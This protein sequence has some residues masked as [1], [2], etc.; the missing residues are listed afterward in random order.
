M[1]RAAGETVQPGGE[2]QPSSST[3]TITVAGIERPSPELIA[4]LI[5][6]DRIFAATW[7]FDRPD[8]RDDSCSAYDMAVANIGVTA[9]LTDK[10]IAGLIDLNRERYPHP[11]RERKGS[12]YMKYI[13]RTIARARAV[14]AATEPESPDLDE[15]PAKPNEQPEDEGAEPQALPIQGQSTPPQP[16]MATP[17]PAENP[18]VA[19]PPAPQAPPAEPESGS[20]SDFSRMAPYPAPMDDAA[21]HGVVGDFVRAVAPHTEADPNVLVVLFLAYTGS[22]LGRDPFMWIGGQKH[23]T[24]IFVDIVGTSSTGR[25]GSANGPLDLFFGQVDSKWAANMQSGLSSGE[26]LI[27]CVRDPISKREKNKK[28]GQYDDV[29]VDEGVSDK[30]ALV[31]QPEF[32]G[33]LQAMRRSGNN[34]SPTI[35]DA[36]DSGNLKTMTKNSPAAAT[37][38]HI[39]IIGNITKE[40]LLRGMLGGEMDNGFA[41][42]F[43]WACS[44]RSKALP[45][46]GRLHELMATELWADLLQRVQR[47]KAFAFQAGAISRDAAASD[48]WGRDNRPGEGAYFDLTQERHGLF[49]AATSRAAPQVLRLSLIYALLDGVRQIRLEH[50]LAAL[51]VWRYCEDSARYIFGDSMGDPTAD[52]ILNGLRQN[53]AGLT[54][55]EI[56]DLFGGNVKAAEIQRALMVLHKAAL[57][58]FEV[59]KKEGKGRKPERWLAVGNVGGRA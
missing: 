19:S 52:S 31:K 56:S 55:K 12:E 51:E 42:R 29:L 45:E 36:W 18:K 33:A 23:H 37:N 2:G 41:N 35:R 53:P 54:R 5:A 43:L 28:T 17:A 39:T 46:G 16:A 25:K 6:N 27:W 10:A 34:L 15:G 22:L 40:E 38:A 57:A 50:L 26:G 3:P 8:F 48:A 11:K 4:A 1:P 14:Q 24:N 32:F 9:G 59:E 49:G 58:R 44:K 47:A 30:R 20:A 7:G 21:Y 13:A